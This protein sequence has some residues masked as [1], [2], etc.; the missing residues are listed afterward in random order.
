MWPLRVNQGQDFIQI[1]NK[2]E[3][4]AVAKEQDRLGM[5][6]KNSKGLWPA[7]KVKTSNDMAHCTKKQII[8]KMMM[9]LNNRIM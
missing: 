8:K 3:P 2:T 5:G 6:Y 7:Q 4:L 1:D 9:M